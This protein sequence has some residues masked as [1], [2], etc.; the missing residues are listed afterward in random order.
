MEDASLNF[1]TY[2]AERVIEYRTAPRLPAYLFVFVLVD[3][4]VGWIVRCTGVIDA[5]KRGRAGWHYR[6][7]FFFDDPKH[8]KPK[9]ADLR[10]ADEVDSIP[11]AA[12]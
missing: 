2:K 11:R 4:A 1:K 9:E 10:A 6:P 3:R 12:V 7:S 5:K 8:K